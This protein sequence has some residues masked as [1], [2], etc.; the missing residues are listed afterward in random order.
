MSLGYVLEKDAFIW[1][2]TSH[3]EIVLAE[4]IY[5]VIE[6]LAEDILH[7]DPPVF[8]QQEL[9]DHMADLHNWEVRTG[10]YRY[11]CARPG[12]TVYSAYSSKPFKQ[13]RRCRDYGLLDGHYC[14][15]ECQ[16]QDFTRHKER[17]HRDVFG[18]PLTVEQRSHLH[19]FRKA[20]RKAELERGPR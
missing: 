1:K 18:G 6:F 15:Q 7:V 9:D 11:R 17:L 12:C 14:S 10:F 13:C 20:T 5:G 8:T 2:M 4:N 3:G 16:K 19:E